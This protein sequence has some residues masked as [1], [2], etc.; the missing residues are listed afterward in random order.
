MSEQRY[1]P[2]GLFMRALVLVGLGAALVIAFQMG[3]E[4]PAGVS[5][6]AARAEAAPATVDL[7]QAATG[8]NVEAIRAALDAGADIN[9][10]LIDRGGAKAG[11]TPLMLACFSGSEDAV[12]VL[13]EAGAKTE[14]R[15]TDGRTALI[16]AAGWGGVDKV[17][18]LIDAGATLDARATDGMTALMFAAVRGDVESVRALVAAGARVDERNR[19][20]QTALMGAARN[21]SIEKVQELINAGAAVD[22]SDQFGDTALSI[23]AASSDAGAPVLELLL[24]AGAQVDKP[25]NDGVT[26]LMKAAEAGHEPKVRVLLAAGADAT[27]K[28]TANGWTARDWAAKRDDATGRTIADI[29]GGGSK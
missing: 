14:A 20:R 22:M 24:E 18:R 29:L 5:G 6:I 7:H 17:R 28:D 19:W 21:G 13:L 4:M 8:G 10:P 26:P 16:Y 15:S 2:V 12:S 11:M 9:A 25:D 23:A 3:R 1:T 27:L